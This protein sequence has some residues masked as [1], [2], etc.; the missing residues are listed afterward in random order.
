MPT[1]HSSPGEPDL[2]IRGGPSGV[3][4]FNRATGLNVLCDEV[5]VPH[6]MWASAPKQISVALTNRCDLSCRYCYAP[7]S[8]ASL[9]IRSLMG[10]LCDF[11]SNGCLGVGFGGGEPTLYGHFVEVCQRVSRET[12]LAVTFTTHGHRIDRALIV[13]LKGSV[14][15]VR[16]S[17]DGTGRT[18]EKMRG[19][20]FQA[21]RSRI[22]LLRALAPLGIN[23]VVNANTWPDLDAAVDL[24]IEFGAA[25][26]LLLP[27]RPVNNKGGI[28]PVTRR[29][30]RKWI[31]AY[32]GQVPLTISQ[33]DAETSPYP[34]FANEEGLRA[35]AHID[36]SGVLKR[37]SYD[38]CGVSIDSEGV[39]GALHQLRAIYREDSV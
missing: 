11:D 13:A 22:E 27:E 30:L 19:R 3:H 24:A 5:R 39:M 12:K 4:L 32:G 28:D 6:A 18:Y 34:T 15:F 25:E 14:H 8:R 35:Y 29:S 1:I 9:D 7:K 10:W 33:S 21:L 20:S 38:S 2:K 23:F 36:A 31:G 16:V 26:F 37:F 17:V